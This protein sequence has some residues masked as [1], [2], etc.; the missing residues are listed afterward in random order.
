MTGDNELHQQARTHRKM[1]ILRNNTPEEI[2]AKNH[3][4]ET[5][6]ITAVKQR[7]ITVIRQLLE[8]RADMNI[9]NPQGDTALHWAI[10]EEDLTIIEMLTSA[11]ANSTIQNRKGES[12]IH[13][14]A[15]LASP[16]ILMMLIQS[17][18][19]AKCNIDTPNADGNSPLLIAVNLQKIKT[20]GWLAKTAANRLI[21]DEDGNMP[22][23][24][25]TILGNSLLAQAVIH[26]LA[27]SHRNNNGDTPIM[28]AT[29]SGNGE[30]FEVILLSTA[31]VTPLDR[32]YSVA[33]G[34]HTTKRD[35]PE[36][37][38]GKENANKGR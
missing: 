6:L 10:R 8:W 7:A 32:E 21:I 34:L 31:Q 33:P 2:N 9:Q 20:A 29:R 30:V 22:L 27:L 35:N 19:L 28:I 11:G 5:P 17:S 37:F 23:H 13:L 36:F 26:Q 12:C 15:A 4:G 24:R 25:A 38:A 3:Q 16:R 14:A 1:N 18:A